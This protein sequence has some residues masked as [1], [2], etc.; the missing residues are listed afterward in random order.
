MRPGVLI[1]GAGLLLATAC[2]TQ[3]ALEQPSWSAP[4]DPMALAA[5]AGLEPTDREYLEH[6]DVVLR[7]P[8]CQG[9]PVA[10]AHPRTT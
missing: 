6:R 5:D 8:M 7:E 1:A 2:S 4:A 9:L 3:A 10:A